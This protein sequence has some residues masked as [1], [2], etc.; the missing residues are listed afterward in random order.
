MTKLWI[1]F[2]TFYDVFIKYPVLLGF[3][4]F[5]LVIFLEIFV[6][7]YFFRRK[8]KQTEA[9]IVDNIQTRD[10]GDIVYYPIFKFNTTEHG[11][12]ET[13]GRTE[14]S[15]AGKKGSK[16][17]IYYDPKNPRKVNYHQKPLEKFFIFLMILFTLIIPFCLAFTNRLG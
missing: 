16:I 15:M 7:P 12:V 1:V 17:T 6:R 2:S 9:L 3:L 8:A 14:K 13:A 4:F 10:E 11:E 5:N